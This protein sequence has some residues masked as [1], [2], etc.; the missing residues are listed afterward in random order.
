[1]CIPVVKNALLFVIPPPKK[2]VAGILD[3]PCLSIHQSV[4]GVV[5]RA[6]A[7][8]IHMY[9]PWYAI[10]WIPIDFGVKNNI[11]SFLKKT[12]YACT[13]RWYPA[14]WALPPC[15][16]MADRALLAGYPRCMTLFL[17][18][19]DAVVRVNWSLLI[20]TNTTLGEGILVDHWSTA[21]IFFWTAV[22]RFCFRF[23]M[24]CLCMTSYQN[25]VPLL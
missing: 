13:C 21:S 6:D 14:K 11:L 9:I 1:M 22:F 7:L 5:S 4:D 17:E 25:W 20:N 12:F 10:V 3:S 2:L 16:C 18:D 8:K 15:L 23:Y 19:T 24:L